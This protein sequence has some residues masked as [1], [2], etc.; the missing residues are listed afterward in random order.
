MVRPCSIT[1]IG[2]HT[3]ETHSEAMEIKGDIDSGRGITETLNIS[4]YK[5]NL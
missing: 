3:T 1:A 4:L 5:M 2:Q